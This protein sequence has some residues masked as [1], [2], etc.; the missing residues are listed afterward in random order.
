MDQASGRVVI[1]VEL[2]GL[3][4]ELKQELKQKQGRSC[5][6]P[7]I[8]KIAPGRSYLTNLPVYLPT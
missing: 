3:E 4:P 8:G 6:T 2:G 1:D 5:W 7:A